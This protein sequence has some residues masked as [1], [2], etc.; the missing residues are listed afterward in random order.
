V[1]VLNAIFY[2]LPSTPDLRMDF[3]ESNRHSTYA[4]RVRIFAG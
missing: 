2:N 3:G 1:R 4:N